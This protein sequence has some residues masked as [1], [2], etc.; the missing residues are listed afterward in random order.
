MLNASDA[1][2]G[3]SLPRARKRT[4]HAQVS[5]AIVI[6]FAFSIRRLFITVISSVIAAAHAP[7]GAHSRFIV[8]TL[9]VSATIRALRLRFR[10]G[11]CAR[12]CR[13]KRGG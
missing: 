6:L 1:E 3:A 7:R 10:H 5:R 4:R 11:R 12:A 9:S 13:G 8:R 2:K